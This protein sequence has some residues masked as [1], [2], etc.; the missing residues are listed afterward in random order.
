MR[1][2][3]P[4]GRGTVSVGPAAEL[5]ELDVERHRSPVA[6]PAAVM[7][8]VAVAVEVGVV[9]GAGRRGRDHA[10]GVAA[11]A[12]LRRTVHRVGRVRRVSVGLVV[13]DSLQGGV[14]MQVP[15]IP[16]YNQ[17]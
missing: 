12:A 13:H 16:R 10:V 15:F 17:F 6:G 8:A 5:V 4:P 11:D 1:G 2:H 3:S 9:A 14:E 7:R